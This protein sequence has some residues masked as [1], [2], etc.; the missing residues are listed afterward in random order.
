M[1]PNSGQPL[2]RITAFVLEGCFK[3]TAGV[4]GRVNKK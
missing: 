4:Q 3:E 1:L 2:L